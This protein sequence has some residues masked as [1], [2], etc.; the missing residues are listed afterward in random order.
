MSAAYFDGHLISHITRVTLS[1]DSGPLVDILPR[2]K[3]G[4]VRPSGQVDR[5]ISLRCS[6]HCS[7]KTKTEME[8]FQHDLNE[9]VALSDKST[10]IV[11]G[12]TYEDVYL[13]NVNFNNVVNNEYLD[14]TIEAM[15]PHVGYFRD[16]QVNTAQVRQCYFEY[17]YR[18][19]ST[20][21]GSFQF[22]FYNNFEMSSSVSFEDLKRPRTIFANGVLMKPVGGI[23][24]VTLNCFLLKTPTKEIESYFYNMICGFGPLGKQGTLYLNGNEYRF[25]ILRNVSHDDI[26][27][28]SD[29]DGGASMVR[30][31]VTFTVSVQC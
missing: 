11:N 21:E 9:Q 24:E 2:A 12:N 8:G 6:F 14:Y 22:Q 23:E 30:Y 18:R 5:K 20:D 26:I 7:G 25:A 16:A 28:N 19:S 27:S 4:L 1:G 3:G 17:M 10:L 15:L 13:T 29:A 31:T